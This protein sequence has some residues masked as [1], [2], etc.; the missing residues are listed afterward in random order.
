MPQPNYSNNFI[1]L[2]FIELWDFRRDCRADLVVPNFNMKNQVSE[3]L[4]SLTKQG[5]GPGC[6]GFLLALFVVYPEACIYSVMY[7]LH[8]RVTKIGPHIF[9]GYCLLAGWELDFRFC[10]L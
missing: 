10:D 4:S 7:C 2:H 3:N 1:L 8:F 6:Q 5:I 9:K